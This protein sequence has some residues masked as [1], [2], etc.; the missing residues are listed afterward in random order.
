[1]H[2]SPSQTVGQRG[3]ESFQFGR[4]A[5]W[6]TSNLGNAPSTRFC[7]T[8]RTSG[9]NF[10]KTSRSTRQSNS[11]FCRPN[12]ENLSHCASRRILIDF[13]R[14]LL[15]FAARQDTRY[16]A[17]FTYGRAIRD[18]WTSL[19]VCNTRRRRLLWTLSRPLCNMGLGACARRC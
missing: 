2:Y 10:S 4:S 15:G 17:V 13:A 6:S 14:Q 3:R 5:C 1:M 9:A 8:S 12:W 18:R 16:E 7:R 11:E 19:Y